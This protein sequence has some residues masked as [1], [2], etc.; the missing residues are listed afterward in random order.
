VIRVVSYDG[1][2]TFG[3][4]GP[5][6]GQ[7]VS[8]AGSPNGSGQSGAM[9]VTP[10]TYAWTQVSLAP[11]YHLQVIDCTDRDAGPF[12]QRSTVSGATATFNVQPGESVTCTWINRR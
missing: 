5:G 1:T 4:S 11:G 9:S 8:T 10:G 12:E 7:S 2:G 3:F 6:G